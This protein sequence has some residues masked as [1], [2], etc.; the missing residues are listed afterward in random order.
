MASGIDA[1]RIIQTKPRA[2]WHIRFRHRFPG[3]GAAILLT[4]YTTSLTITALGIVAFS[5]TPAAPP[6]PPPAPPI[7]PTFQKYR[8]AGVLAPVTLLARCCLIRENG[9]IASWLIPAV[10]QSLHRIRRIGHLLLLPRALR[11]LPVGV[12]IRLAPPF[13]PPP[14]I[15]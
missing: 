1:F 7:G 6:S 14:P 8:S 3:P 15:S 13:P 9:I 5:P 4:L 2:I 10:P 11:L 12:L